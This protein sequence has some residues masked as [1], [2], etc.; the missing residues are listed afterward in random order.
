MKKIF[1][2][3]FLLILLI[4]QV[5]SYAT[6]TV[7][8]TL[9][10][11]NAAF[12]PHGGL[13][14]VTSYRPTGAPPGWIGAPNI[15]IAGSWNTDG[16]QV[17]NSFNGVDWTEATGNAAFVGACGSRGTP[18]MLNFNGY[19]WLATGNTNYCNPYTNDVWYSP[20]NGVDWIAATTDAAFGPRDAGT[21]FISYDNRMWILGGGAGGSLGFA[22]W[23]DVWYSTDGTN[24]SNS[25]M[26]APWGPLQGFGCVTFN[27]RMWVIG[28]SFAGGYSNEVWYSTDG[29]DWFEATSNAAF[30]P[31]G[32]SRVVVADGYMIL[33][34]GIGATGSMN[35]TWYSSD[36]VDWTQSTGT[37]YSPGRYQFGLTTISDNQMVMIAGENDGSYPNPTSNDVWMGVING[38]PVP[39]AVT[40]APTSTPPPTWTYTAT[41]SPTV[42]ATVPTVTPSI[43]ETYTPYNTFTSTYT[44]TPTYSVSPT[45]TNTPTI[46]ATYT[47]PGLPTATAT[48]TPLGTPY[49]YYASSDAKGNITFVWDNSDINNSYVFQYGPAL[50][51]TIGPIPQ[52][53]NTSKTTTQFCY[54][55]C[56]LITNT[57]YEYRV[58][59][60]NIYD[61]MALVSNT[62]ITTPTPVPLDII[63][64]PTP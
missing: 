52:T 4:L 48:I 12:V 54:T 51:Y 27:N 13:A 38:T 49:L 55:L 14:A 16:N 37:P 29:T 20:D 6:I 8:W 24:W 15:I 59:R 21:G 53:W 34:G 23:S 11:G 47:P 40:T 60:Y 2:G 30:S 35:D 33:V 17:W 22:N 64:T 32:W 18:E 46:T 44:I 63:V 61:G 1:S 9:L 50:E 25:T 5:N 45:S 57:T 42:T 43:T 26:S 28:G 56:C 62:V 39:T 10:T 58:T 7:D 19:I 41:P 3:L 31:R 36:G